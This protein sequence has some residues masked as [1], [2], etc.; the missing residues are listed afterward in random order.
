MLSY[1]GLGKRAQA[2]Q[3]YERCLDALRHKWGIEPTRE[4]VRVYETILKTPSV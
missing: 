2:L 3:T 1:A 4:T